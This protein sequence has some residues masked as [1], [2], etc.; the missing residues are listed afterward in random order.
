MIFKY[1]QNNK[2]KKVNN[3]YL[4]NCNNQNLLNKMIK[5]YNIMVSSF[6]LS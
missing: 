4:K 1:L 5:N 6:N 3:Y 2:M